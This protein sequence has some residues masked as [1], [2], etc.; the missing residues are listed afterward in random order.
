M[1]KKKRDFAEDISCLHIARKAMSVL[2]TYLEAECSPSISLSPT[3]ANSL[4]Q[5]ILNSVEFAANAVSAGSRHK[6][7]GTFALHENL[8]ELAQLHQKDRRHRL[9]NQL[10]DLAEMFKNIG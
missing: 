10:E 3:K 1:A 5:S 7:A 9:A 6:T 8:L 4:R 2:E